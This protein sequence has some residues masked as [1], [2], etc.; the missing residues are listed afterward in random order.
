LI[1]IEEG[2][3]DLDIF[4]LEF[5][6]LQNKFSRADVNKTC[7]YARITENE[8]FEFRVCDLNLNL[9]TAEYSIISSPLLIGDIGDQFISVE[10]FDFFISFTPGVKDNL[11][12]FDF[13]EITYYNN[14]EFQ[15]D[16][17]QDVS[18]AASRELN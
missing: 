13:H 9:T 16:G 14:F 1:D 2:F 3:L 4:S 12:D 17:L 18:R 11:L 6:Y 7:S 10:G 5:Q 8:R 15:A